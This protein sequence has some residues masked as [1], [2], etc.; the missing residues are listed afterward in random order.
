LAFDVSTFSVVIG[1]GIAGVSDLVVLILSNTGAALVSVVLEVSSTAL[2]S[3]SSTR[4]LNSKLI[5]IGSVFF[6]EAKQRIFLQ[7]LFK[8]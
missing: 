6:T 5:S 1:V 7:F 4:D 8:F 3:G 2:S